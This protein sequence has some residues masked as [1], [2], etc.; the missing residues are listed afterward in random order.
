VQSVTPSS[1][2][3][4]GDARLTILGNGFTLDN[5][6][7][8]V[9]VRG[10]PCHVQLV[11]MTQIES[12]LA[13]YGITTDFNGSSFLPGALHRPGWISSGPETQ[14]QPAWTK[15]SAGPGVTAVVM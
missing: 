12:V 8:R 14:F 5:K 2:C 4:L 6:L 11:T 15:I 7:V 1:A 13:A 3:L 10:D 9:S